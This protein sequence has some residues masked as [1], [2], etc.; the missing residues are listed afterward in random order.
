[1]KSLRSK[2]FEAIRK[3]GASLSEAIDWM[4]VKGPDD[5]LAVSNSASQLH[6]Y[7]VMYLEA[8]IRYTFTQTNRSFD[9]AFWFYDGGRSVLTSVDADSPS[10]PN[11]DG[12]ID[13]DGSNETTWF[14][15]AV[16]GLYYWRWGAYGSGTGSAV[17]KLTPEPRQ[18]VIYPPALKKPDFME[19][20]G[21]LRE[22]FDLDT[23]GAA[24]AVIPVDG[25]VFW[26]PLDADYS[27]D[28]IGNI[29]FRFSGNAQFQL[30]ETL[31]T[32]TWHS[33]GTEYMQATPG[34]GFGT[35]TASLSCWIRTTN[36]SDRHS[37]FGYG[38]DS[39]WKV[40]CIQENQGAFSC[41]R[42]SGQI[43]MGI[44]INDG[45]W[46]HLVLS[47]APGML[48]GYCD[49]RKVFEG[50]Y[51][52]NLSRDGN[53]A[54]GSW[55]NGGYNGNGE[56]LFSARVYNTV[57]GEKQ[58]K[59]LF[60]N[61]LRAVKRLQTITVNGAA[62]SVV[63]GVYLLDSG[64][65]DARIWKK[66]TDSACRI[67]RRNSRWELVNGSVVC[68]VDVK[69]AGDP[70]YGG[71]KAEDGSFISTVL[72]CNG[73]SSEL[74][75][76][77]EGPAAVYRLSGAGSPEVN[78]PYYPRTDLAEQLY[79]TYDKTKIF[80]NTAAGAPAFCFVHQDENWYLFSYKAGV[81]IGSEPPFYFWKGTDPLNLD[82]YSVIFGVSPFP[83]ITEA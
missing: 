73:V 12:R 33:A 10:Q 26:N 15:P 71:Y 2:G 82:E 44:T 39:S 28:L 37:F 68:A 77:P 64:T 6:N 83:V 65:G 27:R 75:E 43:G 72:T 80:A 74:L 3:N 23:F 60:G 16:S 59:A 21:Y 53:L 30:D 8:G 46:H 14:T 25:L 17:L 57:L 34:D 29:P 20:P 5:T 22:F 52:F 36:S 48:L 11:G 40:L 81:V 61:E 49:G 42:G 9:T 70:W 24:E 62:E 76:D 67:L 55:I 51:E 58:V 63:N 54:I 56:S 69:A 19:E 66:Q 45:V 47:I 79:E 7:Y 1:M 4:S 41:E 78:G 13:N 32:Q 50:A 38:T 35:T 18:T 31:G